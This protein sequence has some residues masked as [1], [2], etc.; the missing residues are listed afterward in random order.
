MKPYFSFL[1][2]IFTL[3]ACGD[4]QSGLYAF[5]KGNCSKARRLW[6]PLAEKGQQN[7]SYYLGV[8]YLNGC[9]DM[10]PNYV[11]A[12]KWLKQAASH[13]DKDAAF[14]LS[15]LY[16][17]MS[18]SKESIAW[19]KK[20]SDWGDGY[21]SRDLADY[22]E[23]EGRKEKAKTYYIKAVKQGLVEFSY[24]DKGE[25][26]IDMIYKMNRRKELLQSHH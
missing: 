15:E 13:Y 14:A 8:M 23:E 20:A 19:L 10:I 7:A 5:D 3:C 21:A 11:K 22:Y 4:F 24:A 18:K 9:P 17:L 2:V 6:E 16:S 1:L 25:E 26:T 12:A